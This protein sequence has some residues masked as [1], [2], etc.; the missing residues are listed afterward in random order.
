MF[1][2]QFILQFLYFLPRFFAA[3]I[4]SFNGLFTL[5]VFL[6]V[7]KTKKFMR[8]YLT[9]L[10]VLS[11]IM[12]LVTMFYFE[13]NNYFQLLIT[14]DMMFYRLL[15]MMNY[16]FPKRNYIVGIIGLVLSLIWFVT[17]YHIYLEN[18]INF[19][20]DDAGMLYW[21]NSMTL[22]S[23]F[24][25]LINTTNNII[26]WYYGIISTV[27]GYSL[28]LLSGKPNAIKLLEQK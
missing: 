19:A 16:F 23:F 1:D 25:Y 2:P 13:I 7:L 5:S 8:K 9:E 14:V 22:I 24:T 4:F 12:Q 15:M 3:S 10:T 27:L 26:I 21:L 17:A 20:L 18:N 28:T 11:L 6:L